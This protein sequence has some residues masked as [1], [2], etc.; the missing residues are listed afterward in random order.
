MMPG[1]V[2]QSMLVACVP[3]N[4][5]PHGSFDQEMVFLKPVNIPL[6]EQ[7]IVFP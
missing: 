7:T 6:D 1:T 2:P 4:A 3:I 5:I